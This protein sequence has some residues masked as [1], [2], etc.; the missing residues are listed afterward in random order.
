MFTHLLS[1]YL[2]HSL[3]ILS[4]DGLTLTVCHCQSCQPMGKVQC[5][6]LRQMP[7]KCTETLRVAHQTSKESKYIDYFM[8]LFSFGSASF[9]FHAL[10]YD[11]VS[12]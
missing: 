12:S 7:F 9:H 3:S 11:A 5:H 6:F 1:L 8:R 10:F 4:P 2:T